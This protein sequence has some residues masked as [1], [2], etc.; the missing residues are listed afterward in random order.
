MLIS[1]LQQYASSAAC[2][3][4]I[5]E[6]NTKLYFVDMLFFQIAQWR[7]SSIRLSFVSIFYVEIYSREDQTAW[8]TDWDGNFENKIVA[9]K[10]DPKHLNMPGFETAQLWNH[11]L[12]EIP[13]LY[14]AKLSCV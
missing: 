10:S 2:M 13:R 5:Y 14:F 7:L 4:F 12:W 6:K 1:Y 11:P 9:P 3:H 8:D